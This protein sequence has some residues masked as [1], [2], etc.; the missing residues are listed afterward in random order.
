MDV[1]H[2]ETILAVAAIALAGWIVWLF[3]RRYQLATQARL[4]RTE[5][6][7]RLIEKFGSAKEFA[8][9]AQSEEGKK[10]LADPVT[11]NPNPLSKVLRYLQAGILFILIGVAYF[12]NASR[13]QFGPAQDPNYFHKAEDF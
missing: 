8:E 2:E 3:F 5:S 6:F 1:I 11:P 13:W 10:L 12:I 7:N 9:F 4:Q